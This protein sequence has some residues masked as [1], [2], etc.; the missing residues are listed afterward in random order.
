MQINK[1][2]RAIPVNWKQLKEWK[3]LFCL[4]RHFQTQ[5]YG[6]FIRIQPYIKESFA[7]SS[8]QH[9]RARDKRNIY[10]FVHDFKIWFCFNTCG[11]PKIV[12]LLPFYITYSYTSLLVV[13]LNHV[14]D[15][16]DFKDILIKIDNVISILKFSYHTLFNELS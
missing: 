11:K 16:N 3:Q 6:H 14:W 12:V 2:I 9:H 1:N 15:Y 5:I 7:S 8:S 13:L 4:P 10:C